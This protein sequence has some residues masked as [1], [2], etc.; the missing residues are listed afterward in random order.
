MALRVTREQNTS[1]DPE[2]ASQ[3]FGRI[4]A[5]LAEHFD[6]EEQQDSALAFFGEY[7]FAVLDGCL[8]P[9]EI[10]HLNE[11]YDR[12]Q[13]ERPD[14]W[15][16]SGDRKFFH[17]NAGIMFSQPLLDYP[18]LDPYTQHRSSYRVVAQILGGEDRVRFSEF[19]FR[20]AP[21]ESGQGAMNFHHDRVAP[22]RF[23]REPYNPCD[24]LCAI[25]YLTDVDE[26]TP[27][28][29]VVPKSN[30]YATLRDAFEGLGTDYHEVPVYGPA[31]TCVLYDTAIFH[32]R[33]DG[34]GRKRRRT[35]HQYY[36]RGGWLR[37][38]RPGVREYV[39]PPAP[40]LTDWNL[41]PERLALHPD[42]RKRLFF[43]HWNTAQCEWVA[44]GFDPDVRRTMPRGE[45]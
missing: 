24:W 19:N 40:V 44:S 11:F 4:N 35:W 7:G 43:S 28:F 30:R 45:Y 16:L 39:R 18:E 38:S 27:A 12:T 22:D 3:G 31:G 32:T 42:P 23:D 29:C 34:D 10:A 15:G 9:A 1:G 26:T 17:R 36:A 21:A 25:H 41:F 8:S 20:E 2:A 13:R 37:S 5:S 14:A 33:L 6:P